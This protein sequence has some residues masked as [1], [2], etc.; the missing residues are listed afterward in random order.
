ME[1]NKIVSIKTKNLYIKN[2]VFRRRIKYKMESNYNYNISYVLSFIESLKNSIIDLL[3]YVNLSSY[4]LYPG[5]RHWK[6]YFREEKEQDK[7]FIDRMKPLLRP[8][9]LKGGLLYTDLIF[10]FT[11]YPLL[12]LYRRHHNYFQFS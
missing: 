1:L 12:P 10:S 11:R 5:E 4:F 6:H 9:S 7:G 8:L 2:Q 3:C